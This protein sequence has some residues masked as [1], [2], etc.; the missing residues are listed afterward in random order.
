MEKSR[1]RIFSKPGE[2]ECTQGGF[3]R[4]NPNDTLF[5]S[6]NGTTSNV[7]SSLQH[8]RLCNFGHSYIC[9]KSMGMRFFHLPGIF[10]LCGTQ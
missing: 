5:T 8:H 3:R 10:S 7:Y 2:V 1:A 4:H 6:P 9:N